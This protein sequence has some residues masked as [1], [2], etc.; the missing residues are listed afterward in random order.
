MRVRADVD[1]PG[2][3]RVLHRRPRERGAPP[4]NADDPPSTKS[5]ARYNVT[6]TLWRTRIGSATSTKSAVPSSKVTTIADSF[7]P[8]VFAAVGVA[9]LG[10]RVAEC[11][12]APRR[13]RGNLLV[14]ARSV[15]IDLERRTATHPVVEQHDRAAH[16]RPQAIGRRRHHLHGVPGER[17]RSS[18]A[19]I[20]LAVRPR[21]RV[22]PDRTHGPGASR[23]RAAR[24]AP[25]ARANAA[26]RADRSWRKPGT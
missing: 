14:E 15:E 13:D 10:Q 17:A 5:V 12:R 24:R 9:S 20:R 6:G 23:G 16:I 18:H 21:A 8:D 11:E 1:E 26:G 4:E 3:A 7:G 19:R 25:A 2:G 22:G